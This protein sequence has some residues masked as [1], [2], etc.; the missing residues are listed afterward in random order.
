MQDKAKIYEMAEAAAMWMVKNQITD[1][2]DANRGRVPKFYNPADNTISFSHNWMTGVACMGLLASYKRTGKQIYLEA[3]ER[4]GR[5]IVA[6]QV[7]DQRDERYY[8]VIRELTPQS[9]EYAP[10]DAT[11]A[12]WALVWLYEATKNPLYLDR[13]VL[14]GNW[15]LRNAMHDG[16]PLY[17][18]YMDPQL[19]N[20]YAKGSFQS[21]TGLFYYDLFMVSGDPRY[22]EFGLKPIAENYRDRFFYDDGM[23]ILER[24]IFTWDIKAAAAQ[25]LVA[26]DMHLYNDDFGA[27]MLQKAAELFK[28]ESFRDQARKYAHWLAVH[29]DADGG[30]LNGNVP[31]GVPVSMMYFHDLGCYYKDDLLLQAR[32]KALQKL[33]ATQFSGT[34]DKGLDGAFQ[35]EPCEDLS[36][37]GGRYMNIRSTAY[38]LMALWKIESDMPGIWLGA[39]NEP[40]VDPLRKGCHKLVW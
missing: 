34:G 36:T 38:A 23:V 2:L 3:A 12:A 17:A 27:A 21:G 37:A 30:Y 20:F 32:D 25:D 33:A 9:L 24:D 29:Q 26:E 18:Q 1:R 14:F 39:H 16:W 5:Y 10:R 11:S 7:M 13:A 6:L 31:A 8:G 40:F 4:A 15:H 28:D 35:G 19:D 22:I